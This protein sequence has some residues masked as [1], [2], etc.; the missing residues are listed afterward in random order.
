MT[1]AE[2]KAKP[3][4][5]KVWVPCYRDGTPCKDPVSSGTWWTKRVA[6]ERGWNPKLLVRATLTIAPKRKAKP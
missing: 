4:T 6:V 5:F 1:K 2:R 3:R